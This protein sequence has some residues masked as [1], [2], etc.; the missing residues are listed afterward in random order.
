MKQ[1]HTITLLL[2][3]A[4][5]SF[6]VNGQENSSEYFSF[7]K[8]INNI[9]RSTWDIGLVEDEANKMISIWN[10]IGEDLK[11]NENDLAGTYFK[12]GYSSGYFL[13]WSPNKGFILIPYFDQ[14]LISQFSYGKV[15]FVDNSEINFIPE[16]D[17]NGG[18]GIA[19]TPLKWTA[20]ENRFIPVEMLGEYG[21]FLAGLKQYN[22]FNGN[23]CEFAPIFLAGR[24]DR[25][26]KQ[27]SYPIPSKYKQFIKK[28]IVSKI[29]FVGIKKIVKNWNF[30][31]ELYG[32]W[33]EKA[34]LIPVKISVGQK[35]G[36]QPNMLF[37][38]IGEPRGQY[39]QIIKVNQLSSEG[40]VVRD[41]SFGNK[42]TYSDFETDQEKPYPAIRVG[43]KV[44][45]SPIL[46]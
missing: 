30:Q 8:W 19:K 4:F 17:L 41:L 42:E 33:M 13:R 32:E 2:L 16:K 45:T 18:R 5:L 46:D 6:P 37:R 34:A 9:G 28:P 35:H 12:G 25:K 11:K 10:E 38:L 15:N 40:Y 29:S 14:N 27:L 20:F 1:L 43:I 44:T 31:G 3:F 23:C 7:P 22:E 21:E 39:L 24:I 26:D 36:V